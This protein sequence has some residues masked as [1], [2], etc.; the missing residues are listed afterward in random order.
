M[1]ILLAAFCLVLLFAACKKSTIAPYKYRGIITGYDL[2][3]CAS[4]MCGG[5][6]IDIDGNASQYRTRET[7][8]ELGINE[9]AKFPINVSLDYRPDTGVFAQ[10]DY[11]IVTKIKVIE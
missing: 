8:T 4:P 9:S 7:L 2:R 11:I 1:K 10:Y 6:F 3:E 5:L